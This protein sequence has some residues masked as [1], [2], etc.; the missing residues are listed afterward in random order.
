MM[1]QKAVAVVFL[2]E[3]RNCERRHGGN[4]QFSMSCLSFKKHIYYSS[5]SLVDSPM[6]YIVVVVALYGF[7]LHGEL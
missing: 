1:C 3:D 7:F 5:G 4:P 2:N 6:W